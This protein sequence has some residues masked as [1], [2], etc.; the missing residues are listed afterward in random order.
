MQ[1]AFYDRAQQ[2]AVP[3]IDSH[4]LR[5][6]NLVQRVPIPVWHHRRCMLCTHPHQLVTTLRQACQDGPSGLRAQRSSAQAARSSSAHVAR[7]SSTHAG[8]TRAMRRHASSHR[9]QA[10]C[11]HAVVGRR[12]NL[13]NTERK[14]RTRAASHSPT[15]SHHCNYGRLRNGSEVSCCRRNH[16]ACPCTFSACLPQPG[17]LCRGYAVCSCT[18][19]NP[20]LLL[21]SACCTSAPCS[22]PGARCTS[23]PCSLPAASCNGSGRQC[24]LRRCC[25]RRTHLEAREHCAAQEDAKLPW[26]G[27]QVVQQRFQLRQQGA[28]CQR[29]R[30]SGSS[31]VHA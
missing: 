23:A 20:W 6:P 2:S 5:S 14:R 4:T 22:L 28:V 1:A 29:A 15:R 25:L 7:S 10:G 30:V 24:C 21:D 26:R 11:P 17:A 18:R 12:Q 27:T 8:I 13:L 3:H 19:A 31:C 16:A 9:E